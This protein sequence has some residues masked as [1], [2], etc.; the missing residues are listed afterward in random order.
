MKPRVSFPVLSGT[1]AKSVRSP[2][3]WPDDVGTRTKPSVSTGVAA[4]DKVGVAPEMSRQKMTPTTTRRTQ[5]WAMAAEVFRWSSRG[6]LAA[7]QPEIS[8]L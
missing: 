5:A 3:G 2:Q 4:R 1:N 7:P 6:D 8:G